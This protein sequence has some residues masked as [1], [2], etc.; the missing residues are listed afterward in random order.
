[1][2]P[3]KQ[4]MAF[5]DDNEK[6]MRKTLDYIQ[7]ESLSE[8]CKSLS[9]HTQ[10]LLTHLSNV[11]NGNDFINKAARLLHDLICKILISLL[12]CNSFG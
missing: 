8:P 1:V 6:N 2:I 4:V 11:T 12:S 5:S 3:V 10:M 7:R 9:L